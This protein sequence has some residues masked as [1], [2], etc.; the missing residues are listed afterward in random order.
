MNKEDLEETSFYDIGFV[1]LDNGKC[2][3]VLIS[4][5]QETADKLYALLKANPPSIELTIKQNKEYNLYFDFAE[6]K[7]R[8]VHEIRATK[9][10][11]PDI[12]LLANS[13]VNLLTS[14]A[15]NYNGQLIFHLDYLA[16]H[17]PQLN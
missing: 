3:L 11:Y 6:A 1:H 9:E 4:E 16:L 10:S 8:I 12:L 17:R 13:K 14:G 15:Y 2:A 5:D 7:L